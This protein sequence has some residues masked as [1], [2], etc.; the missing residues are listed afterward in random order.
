MQLAWRFLTPSVR[1]IALIILSAALSMALWGFAKVHAR[2]A[3]EQEIR[4]GCARQ[5]RAIQDRQAF[6]RK[7]FLPIE[8]CLALQIVR[9]TR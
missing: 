9:E 2:L 7:F 1:T 4:E 6:T 5:V 8:P 3:L